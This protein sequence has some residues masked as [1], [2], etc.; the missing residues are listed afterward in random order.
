MEIVT[1]DL[2]NNLTHLWWQIV[3]FI[4]MQYSFAEMHAEIHCSVYWIH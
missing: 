3:V 1:N 2:I 4:Q